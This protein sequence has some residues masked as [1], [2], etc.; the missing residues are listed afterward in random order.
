MLHRSNTYTRINYAREW[1]RRVSTRSGSHSA[2]RNHEFEVNWAAA[3]VSA[4]SSAQM[5]S[6]GFFPRSATHTHTHTHT[7]AHMQIAFPLS[8]NKTNPNRAESARGARSSLREIYLFGCASHSVYLGRS[9]AGERATGKHV[10]HTDI[11]ARRHTHEHATAPRS[12]SRRSQWMVRAHTK[13]ASTLSMRRPAIGDTL[14]AVCGDFL[15]L[16]FLLSV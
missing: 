10:C 6:N 9:C 1:K 16:I 2:S 8:A 12:D 3:C 13:P 14:G 4:R 11:S 5:L 7:P 15:F